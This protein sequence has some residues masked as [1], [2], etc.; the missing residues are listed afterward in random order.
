[1]TKQKK[2]RKKTVEDALEPHTLSKDEKAKKKRRGQHS[3][4]DCGKLFGTAQAVEDHMRSKHR[5]EKNARR[6]NKKKS[7]PHACPYCGKAFAIVQELDQHALSC[8]QGK[9]RNSRRKQN[10]DD[11]AC[12]SSGKSFASV[13]AVGAGNP[14]FEY[15]RGNVD[16]GKQS[17]NMDP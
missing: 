17:Y 1:M 10:K 2:R 5:E 16:L 4:A 7:K 3:C 6:K 12:L 14:Y 11:H 9:E 13:M 8:K 15:G